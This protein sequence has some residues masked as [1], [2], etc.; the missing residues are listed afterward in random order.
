MHQ[1]YLNALSISDTALTTSIPNVLALATAP[2]IR[3]DMIPDAGSRVHEISSPVSAGRKESL[4]VGAIVSMECGSGMEV[5]SV[6]WSN[7]IVIGS[8]VVAIVSSVFDSSYLVQVRPGQRL[9]PCHPGFVV[10]LRKHC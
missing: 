8:V 6:F 2:C 10:Y 1:S 9:H 7:V 4:S 3:S 5:W